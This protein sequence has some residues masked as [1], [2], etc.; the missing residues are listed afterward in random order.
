MKSEEPFRKN[1]D[2][3]LQKGTDTAEKNSVS[4][5]GKI[6]VFLSYSSLNKNVADAVVADFEQ[7]G[8]RC[9]YAPRDI[10]PGQEWVTAIHEAIKS[11]RLFVLIYTDS[12]NES[13]QVANEVALAFNS[14]KTLI[15]FKLSDAE[16]SSE[17]E[18]YLTRVHWLD[19]VKPPLRQS[20]ESLRN[21]SETILGGKV[22][23][24]SKIRNSNTVRNKKPSSFMI[25]SAVA[26]LAVI[27]IAGIFMLTK[28]KDSASVSSGKTYEKAYEYQKA[29]RNKED[30]DKAY[31]C[32]MQTGDEVCSDEEITEAVF[33]LASY[34]YNEGSEESVDRAVQ[35]YKKAAASGS[36]SASNMLAAYYLE[37]GQIS[38]AIRYYEASAEKGDA[39]ALYSLGYIYENDAGN[40]DI[41][42]DN[43]KALAYYERAEKAGHESA[44]KACERIRKKTGG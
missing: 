6:D 3:V 35:L 34:Y 7:H 22:P 39:V 37:N 11:C 38:D 18:Y 26:A 14:G 28:N 21:Y 15:P 33:E 20:I 24:E 30:Y 32:Y 36:V 5:A 8:I 12:S 13:K 4:A 16:M 29:A 27:I 31:D 19:A 1:L 44:S 2:E 9:W 40:Y 41:E 25:I 43:V 17:L 42:P 10:I 23:E